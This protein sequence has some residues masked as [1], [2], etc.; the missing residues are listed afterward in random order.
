MSWC[1]VAWRCRHK[2]AASYLWQAKMLWKL[3][4]FERKRRA[5]ASKEGGYER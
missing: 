5:R 3:G 2:L 4:M 1:K